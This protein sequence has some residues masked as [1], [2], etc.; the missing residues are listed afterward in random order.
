MDYPNIQFSIIIPC[1]N[2]SK[3]LNDCFES[4]LCQGF[5]NWEAILVNDG[6]KDDTEEIAK[7]LIKQESRIKYFYQENRGLSAARNTGMA[8]A[9]GEYLLFLDADDWLYPDCLKTYSEFLKE[10]PKSELFRCGYSYWNYPDGRK[11][12]SHNPGE[13]GLIY[14]KV[15]TQNIGPCHSILIRRDF[16]ECFGGF[17]SSLKSCED[18][19]FWIRAGKM[20]AR[21]E[22]ISET[23]VA[24]R[25]VPNSMSRNPQVMYQALTEVSQRAGIKDPRLPKDAPFN[26]DY[27]LDYAEIQKKHLIRMLGVMLHQGKVHEAIEWYREEKEKWNWKIKAKDWSGLSSYLSWGYFF[28]IKDI[29][30]LQKETFLYVEHFFIHLGYSKKESLNH[31]RMVFAPQLKK[32]NHIRYGKVF[33]AIINRI[34]RF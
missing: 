22:S 6:S 1:Y 10:N 11:Y 29:E 17:D 16:A 21:M 26:Q 9:R 20:G 25:Y 7:K 32:M 24:Y 18:W 15:L 12:H 23:L 19:D 13:D 2:H 33:G 27:D 4:I 14:P 8:V 3:Y 30:E 5:Q 31:S 34:S 28:E